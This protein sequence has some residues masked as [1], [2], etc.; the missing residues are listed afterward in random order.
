MKHIILFLGAVCA[1]ASS[2][3]FYAATAAAS[4][5][6]WATQACTAVGDLCHRPL[7]FAVA[8]AAFAS[9]WLMTALS[10]II[11]ARD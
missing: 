1:A 2:I 4:E 7:S 10:R 6:H 5:A 9:L 8:A 3:F 11:K